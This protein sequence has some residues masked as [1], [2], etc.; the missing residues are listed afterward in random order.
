MQCS[1]GTEQNRSHGSGLVLATA[2]RFD[3]NNAPAFSL[4]IPL[5]VF[6]SSSLHLLI[7]LGRCLIAVGNARLAEN[8]L[9]M[10]VKLM[11]HPDS[12]LLLGKC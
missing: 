11:V 2:K 8:F 5:L 7:A 12:I 10:S 9:Q 3:I 4:F 1:F 6:V